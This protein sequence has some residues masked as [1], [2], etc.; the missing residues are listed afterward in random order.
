MS[1]SRL[2]SQLTPSLFWSLALLLY[3]LILCQ[4]RLF[5]LLAFEFSFASAIPLSVLGARCG[6][7]AAA[8]SARPFSA[9]ARGCAQLTAFAL[10]PLAPICLNALWVRNCDWLGGLSFYLLLACAGGWVGAAWGVA[11][12]GRGRGLK[13]FLLLALLSLLY[14]VGTFLGSPLVD[15][16]HPLW[17]YYPG[18]LYDEEIAI[19][20]R[21]LLSR[22]EDLSLC[23]LAILV[24][25]RH[26]VSWPR[27]LLPLSLLGVL[28]SVS[29]AVRA[30]VHRSEGT[31]QRAL[32]GQLESEHFL[33]YY[34]A[35][36]GTRRG[37]RWLAELEFNHQELTRFFGRAPAS[38]VRAYL[39]LSSRQKKRLMGAGRTLISKPWQRSLHVH[40]VKIGARVVRHE[41]AHAFSADWAD[42]PHHLSLASSGLPHMPLIEGLAV[43]ATWEM[44]RLDPHRWSAATVALGIAPPLEE[45]LSSERFY[46]RSSSLAY[47]L[48]GSFVRFYL[49]EGGEDPARRREALEAL[50]R[51]GGASERALGEWIERWGRSLN[52]DTL[53]PQA[54]NWAKGRYRRPSVFYKVC[55]HE[56]AA[57]RAR[58]AGAE[59]RR[60]WGEARAL[61]RSILSDAPGDPGARLGLLRAYR[62]LELWDD[63]EEEAARL[64]ERHGDGPIALTVREWLADRQVAQ[65]ALAE[66]RARYDALLSLSFERARIR[67]LEVKRAALDMPDAGPLVARYLS[68]Q[69]P[70][71]AR[72]AATAEIVEAAPEWPIG[73]YLQGRAT[74]AQGE[75]E[76][77]RD[78]LAR[79]LELGLRAPSLRYEVERLL[80]AEAFSA[81][82]WDEAEARYHAL[83]LREGLAIEE[84]ER[85]TLTRWARRARAFRS[86]FEA[87]GGEAS[88]SAG[89]LPSGPP[90]TGATPR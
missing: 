11:L 1:L 59:G 86:F 65:G 27:W 49:D 64:L 13:S 26:K 78:Q 50:Y 77:G 70:A 37:T 79:S 8:G 85:A 42:A 41:L 28:A 18:S 12:A 24:A 83:S 10:I 31:I 19:G 15:Q 69:L 4:L 40:G 88:P 72:G 35:R 61:W 56:I 6:L 44:G 5:N 55:A 80:A 30:S 36:W 51:S 29:L 81:G 45:S 25:W 20:G 23:T 9:W 60:A 73:V 84:G 63:F 48:C 87:R 3:A 76:A 71:E 33:L 17:G 66:A 53:S 21:L 34:P 47:T 57:R 82:H 52:A 90:S 62:K 67:R 22:L 43:A 7:R 54:L 58:A 46:L 2:K 89:E 75:R 68:A 74:L 38:K 39:Y 32:G 16:F 14:C